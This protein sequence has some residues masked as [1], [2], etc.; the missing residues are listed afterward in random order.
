MISVMG[1]RWTVYGDL[2][3]FRQQTLLAPSHPKPYSRSV[4][5]GPSI[6]PD[7]LKEV[8]HERYH[9]V[10]CLHGW[11]GRGPSHGSLRP[12]K[13]VPAMDSLMLGVSLNE[14]AQKVGVRQQAVQTRRAL[15]IRAH[16]VI[17]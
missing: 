13:C 17:I 3:R 6:V 8:A 10:C 5:T 9:R 12:S 2:A 1:L 11:V 7:E 4:A 15:A 16:A 14:D